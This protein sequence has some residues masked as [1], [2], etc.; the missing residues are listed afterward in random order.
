MIVN[1]AQQRLEEIQ[2]N[3]L[4]LRFLRLRNHRSSPAHVGCPASDNP[5]RMLTLCGRNNN[6]RPI[7]VSGEE[8][9][10]VRCESALSSLSRRA[11]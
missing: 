4:A 9:L 11:A 2:A 5:K 6:R 10:C 3:G 8:E 1:E 7:D